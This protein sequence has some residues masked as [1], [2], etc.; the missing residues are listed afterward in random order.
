MRSQLERGAATEIKND[1]VAQTLDLARSPM[2]QFSLMQE[3]HSYLNVG[4]NPSL[5]TQHCR[6]PLH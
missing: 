3:P 4:T 5:K 6:T 1:D 2:Q